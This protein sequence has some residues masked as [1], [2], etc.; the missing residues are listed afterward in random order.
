MTLKRGDTTDNH[1]LIIMEG[2]I[3]Y[4]DGMRNI[5]EYGSDDGSDDDSE[6]GEDETDSESGE[7]DSEDE[8]DDDRSHSGGNDE[9]RS[10]AIQA[11]YGGAGESK[12]RLIII[13]FPAGF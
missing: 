2:L 7:D 12:T 5:Q 6:S 4:G 8:D 3:S 1:G 11:D 9:E 10:G 13:P